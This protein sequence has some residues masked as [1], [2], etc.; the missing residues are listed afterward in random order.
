MVT[1]T[2]VFIYFDTLQLQGLELAP[3]LF[4]YKFIIVSLPLSKYKPTLLISFILILGHVCKELKCTLDTGV[5]NISWIPQ[6][7]DTVCQTIRLMNQTPKQPM[8]PLL[9]L[10]CHSP[11]SVFS[12]SGYRLVSSLSIQYLFW[13]FL[14]TFGSHSNMLHIRAS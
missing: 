1:G 3:L 2:E 6:R 14:D 12:L 4:A 13:I 10:F 5:K 9:R 7:K 8:V 11:W